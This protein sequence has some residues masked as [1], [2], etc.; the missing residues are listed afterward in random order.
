MG[1]RRWGALGLGGAVL[2][3]AGCAHLWAPPSPTV[4]FAPPVVQGERAEILVSVADVP[5]GAGALAVEFGGFTYPAHKLADLEV[6]GIGG[7]VVLAQRFEAGQGGFVVA[8]ISG[9][10]AGPVAR[11]TFRPLAPLDPA[12][13]AVDENR[14][15]LADEHNKLVDF[16]LSQPAYYAR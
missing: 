4:I 12:D 9:I 2:A 16:E 3:L 15:S 7:F 8:S 5:G 13:F 10:E 6:E 14:V 1:I 11:I